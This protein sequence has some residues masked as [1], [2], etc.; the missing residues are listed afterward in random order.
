LP[1]H[2]VRTVAEATSVLT[3]VPGPVVAVP[4][5]NSPDDVRACMAALLEHTPTSAPILVIDDASPDT[6][7][8]QSVRALEEGV[9]HLVVLLEHAV[10]TGF[11]GSCNDAFQASDRRD[12]VLVN[13]DVV[14][15]PEWLERMTAAARSSNTVATVST[16]TNHGSILSVPNRN[17]PGPLPAG[18]TPTEAA[19]R[20]A[21]AAACTRP[22]LPTGVGHCLYVTRTALDVVGGFDPVFAPGYGEEVDFCLRA[23]EHGLLNVLA[24]D[25]F[26]YHKGGS[27][28]GA[29][30]QKLQLQADHEAIVNRRHPRYEGYRI[31]FE[32]ATRTAFALALARARRAL[33]G[34]TVAVDGFSLGPEMMGT[35]RFV[36]ETACALA[37]A[38]G[39]DHVDLYTPLV[40]PDYVRR[41][42]EGRPRLRLRPHP[43]FELAP[44]H[45]DVAVR[46]YQVDHPVQLQWMR[47]MADA[48]VVSQLD[49]IAYHNPGYFGS[50]DTLRAY[51]EIT[52]AT[53]DAVDG[54]AFISSHSRDE[55]VREGLLGRQHHWAIT[56]CGID[57]RSDSV[58]PVPPSGAPT[59]RPGFVLVLGAA[60]LHKHR[61]H[62]IEMWRLL[63]ERGFGGQLALVGPVPGHGSSTASETQWLAAHPDLAAEVV[64]LPS[65]AE[66]EKAWLLREAGVV[67]YPTLSEG[68]GMVPFEAALV[69]TPVVTT[70]QGALDEVLPTDLATLSSMLPVDA[71]AL[72][73]RLLH[74]HTFRAQQVELLAAAARRFTWADSA[75]ALLDL[76]RRALDEPAGRRLLELPTPPVPRRSRAG[77][78][79]R[80]VG[81]TRALPWLK[82]LVVGEG[83]RRQAAVRRAANWMRRKLS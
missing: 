72:A 67:A 46:P 48:V 15:G 21:A 5:Y 36:V 81:V 77:L 38:A 58:H 18:L 10:N 79:D 80:L 23:A 78:V 22:V 50:D 13:S 68:F 59:L 83:T 24:D 29:S 69:G 17:R 41:A 26:V 32:S 45:Y 16:L 70:R 27:S 60:Y 31:P 20:V 49:L 57:H 12:V 73:E 7:A 37:D 2:V 34:V 4:V 9:A 52:A 75:A 28:F 47:Q 40:V 11:V 14:V 56:H 74:D 82:R 39:V 66:N 76:M 8:V 44:D 54:V 71:V 35:Q 61:M 1:L 55:A 25:V 3:D 64:L 42:A 62:A 30:P 6:T 53:F 51:R 33:T 65:V 63:R 43:A 19:V